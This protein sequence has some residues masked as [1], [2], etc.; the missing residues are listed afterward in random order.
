M[1][2]INLE[3]TGNFLKE[4]E[5]CGR[6]IG[7]AFPLVAV[8]A[9]VFFLAVTVYHTAML[10]LSTLA[11]IF[12]GGL[13][14]KAKENWSHHAKSAGATLAFSAVIIPLLF[15]FSL[16]I[17]GYLAYDPKGVGQFLIDKSNGQ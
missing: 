15:V 14:D 7:C 10:A 4:N 11:V 12:T 16:G 8:A 2:C 13:Y 6:V 5:C 3:N 1:N 17:G 9:E